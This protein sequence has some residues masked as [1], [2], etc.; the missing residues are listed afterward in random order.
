MR[1]VNEGCVV[2]CSMQWWVQE[3]WWGGWGSSPMQGTALEQ[4][5]A[6]GAIRFLIWVW[7][8]AH[9]SSI[10]YRY[11]S[12]CGVVWC[13]VCGVVWCGV[14]WCGVV[15]YGVVWCGVVWCGVV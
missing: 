9:R 14:V 1:G 8:S 12:Y 4:S 11:Y 13:S 10:S 5:P 15:W 6:R 3:I 2:W 7:G